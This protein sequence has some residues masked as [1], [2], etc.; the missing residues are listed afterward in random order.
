MFICAI[1]RCLFAHDDY[2]GTGADLLVL[3]KKGNKVFSKENAASMSHSD[4]FLFVYP[5][6]WEDNSVLILPADS[7][8]SNP[9]GRIS[10]DI[11]SS[12]SSIVQAARMDAG[13]NAGLG[14]YGKSSLYILRMAGPFQEISGM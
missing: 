1:L 3:D 5:L 9:L 8:E 12:K 10:L 7:E 2:V 6:T 4:G 11:R 14:G 13:W